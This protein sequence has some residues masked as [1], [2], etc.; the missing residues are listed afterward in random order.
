MKK[1]PTP[2]LTV[3]DRVQTILDSAQSHAARSV[4]TTEVV[5][6]WLIGREIVEEQQQGAKRAGYGERIVP[7][8]ARRLLDAGMQGDSE[9][10]LRLCREF[11][12][13]YPDL[14]GAE[15]CYALRNK[16]GMPS[17]G[18]AVRNQSHAVTKATK[19]CHALRGESPESLILV[20][21]IIEA[22]RAAVTNSTF[23]RR[24]ISPQRFAGNWPNSTCRSR[25]RLGNDH[26]AK[27]PD[28]IPIPPTS[29]DSSVFIL[30]PFHT[31]L[32]ARE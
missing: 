24:P 8:L 30:L 25:S 2:N 31:D 13:G 18:Y 27:K 7:E 6:N 22:A 5:A 14:P 4:N 3:F 21:Q 26:L 15:I 28:A 17:I 11:Y 19:I 29:A 1:K 32:S 20:P 23:P 12:L 10:T 16:L 9:L